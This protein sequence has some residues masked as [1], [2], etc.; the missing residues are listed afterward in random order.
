MAQDLIVSDQTAYYQRAWYRATIK[1][2]L[3][4]S[5]TEVLGRM[6]AVNPFVLQQTQ[7]DAWLVQTSI[8][9]DQLN[10]LSGAIFLEY[11]IPRMG[12]RIDAV[13]IIG[14]VLFVIEFK[15]GE[16]NFDQAAK[17]QVWDY[18]LD[19]KNFHLGSHTLPIVPILV[20]TEASGGSDPLQSDPRPD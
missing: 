13:L 14:S 1:E 15:V 17:E 12:R 7:R 9:Q 11:S 20:A 18:A 5:P 16:A 4:A 10:E 6:A 19:L 2:F 3:D 8:L